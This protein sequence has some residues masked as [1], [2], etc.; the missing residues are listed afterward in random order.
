MQTGTTAFGIGASSPQDAKTDQD[1][2]S[3]HGRSGT[4][5]ITRIG[6]GLRPSVRKR[7]EPTPCDVACKA[8]RRLMTTSG[9]SGWF[10]DTAPTP[11][12]RR[13]HG[14][15]RAPAVRSRERSR[16]RVGNGNG[17]RD[18][19]RFIPPAASTT[20]RA[21]DRPPRGRRGTRGRGP[22]KAHRSARRLLRQAIADGAGA[23]SCGGRRT[24]ATEQR[25]CSVGASM[26][27]PSSLRFYP[28]RPTGVLTRRE[29][30]NAR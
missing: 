27:L 30:K 1:D 28:R 21:N 10:R 5:S 25:C 4:G 24:K 12:G 17:V 7:P 14:P 19:P 9:R 11:W 15:G 29:M 22:S 16:R 2:K 6:Q 26:V 13:S 23:A 18:V 8:A 3:Q 20:P